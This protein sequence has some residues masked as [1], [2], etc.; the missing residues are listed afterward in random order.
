MNVYWSRFGPGEGNFGDRITPLLL[1]HLGVPAN[2]TPVK[3]AELVGVGSILEKIPSGY[4]GTVWSSGLMFTNSIVDLSH[5]DVLAV[6]GALTRDRIRCSNRDRVVLGDGGLLC[7]LLHPP[8]TK[9]Y[10]LGLIPHVVD[11]DDPVV[12]ELV[13][14]NSEITLIDNCGRSES[15]LGAIGACRAIL[16]SSLHGLVVADS[17]GVPNRWMELNRGPETV[18][19]EG[20]KF[21]DYYSVFG[22]DP[23]PPYRLA[24]TDT[25]NGLLHLF[26]GYARPGLDRIQRGLLDGLHT[27]A[28]R[29]QQSRGEREATAAEAACEWKTRLPRIVG[30]LETAVPDGATCILI[31]E[32]QLRD[33]LA[34]MHLVPFVEREG[35]YWGPPADDTEAL[36][37]LLRSQENGASHL[38][39]IWSTFW[40]LE[41]YPRFARYLRDQCRC[42]VDNPDVVVFEFTPRHNAV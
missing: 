39:L 11:R 9:R 12:R 33:Q 14:A 27:V 5:A 30:A 29:Y 38:A 37:E 42:L 15:I 25:I 18:R 31:D 22:I 34:G 6:R 8:V 20:F 24:S 32:D 26:D 28:L 19:G 41:Q 23:G 3:D 16:S 2:C 36:T 35:M 17:L 13:A 21:R 40:W 4:R 7:H 10:A 1:N